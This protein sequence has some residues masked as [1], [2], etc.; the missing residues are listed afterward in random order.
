[1][2]V[3]LPLLLGVTFVDA[4]RRA[5]K[6]Q[7]VSAL[8]AIDTEFASEAAASA[9]AGHVGDVAQSGRGHTHAAAR[10]LPALEAAEAKLCTM[11]PLPV[12]S[13]VV[14]F[15]HDAP[16]EDGFANGMYLRM[17]AIA[18]SLSSQGLVVHMVFHETQEHSPISM[19]Q[20]LVYNGS[21][22]EQYQQAQKAAKKQM[23]L[24]IV[25]A[26]AVTMRMATLLRNTGKQRNI[27]S[28][29]ARR[30]S[31]LFEEADFT[32]AWPEEAIATR[33]ERDSVP[34][35]IVTDDIHH[36]RAALIIEESQCKDACGTVVRK[37]LEH[38]ELA[39]YGSAGQIFTVTEEV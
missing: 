23:R 3:L 8:A 20:Q 34:I 19:P 2:A 13:H 1:M 24:G 27:T 33:M 31:E 9:P 15:N 16:P 25:F 18:D 30:L 32:Q 36:L 4:S 22:W 37:Y 14:L 35:A 7:D 11:E 6:L 38:R 21:M 39:L 17:M 12:G 5:R 29:S 26:T 10:G 28:W